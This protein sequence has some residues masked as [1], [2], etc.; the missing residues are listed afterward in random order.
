MKSRFILFLI[1]LTYS[2]IAKLL[3]FKNTVVFIY[4]KS[5][6][7]YE[8]LD[9]VYGECVK[10]NLKAIKIEDTVY[11]LHNLLTIAKARIICIDQATKITSRLTINP[12]TKVIQLWH[13]GGAFKKVG[14]DALVPG[15][16]IQSE[17]NRIKR[18]HSNYSFL[19]TSSVNV[20]KFYKQAFRL[21]THQ[22]LNFGLPRSDLLFKLN[23]DKIKELFCKKYKISPSDK[24]VLYAPTFKKEKNGR[25][26]SDLPSCFKLLE[27]Y[28]IKL[29]VRSH[30]T[31]INSWKK[32]F[33]NVNIIDAS[34][35]KLEEALAISD[36]LITDFSSIV[37]DFSFF[38]R[39][40]VFYCRNFEEYLKNQRGIYLSIEEVFGLNIAKS[41]D[42]LIKLILSPHEFT[43]L[44]DDYMDSCDGNSSNRVAKLINNLLRE[45]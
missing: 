14:F 25:C 16:D 30:P 7:S 45:K 41:E 9:C 43:N 29:L 20:N 32:H 40:I 22:I 3:I 11:S 23:I 26:N 34:N 12:N 4:S 1:R 38:K 19:I 42:D 37:F 24:I 36:I 18:I 6:I 10:I 5:S 13:A 33:D 35:F 27:Q 17:I 15:A 44:W 28:N 2:I 31:I 39:P 21:E 8:N